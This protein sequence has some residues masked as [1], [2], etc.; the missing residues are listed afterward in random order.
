[1]IVLF[2][3]VGLLEK[4]GLNRLGFLP[5]ADANTDEPY[6]FWGS[7]PRRNSLQASRSIT[8]SSWVEPE[9]LCWRV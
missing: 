4:I 9:S 7:L 8:R 5:V 2:S 1:M 3:F 6:R